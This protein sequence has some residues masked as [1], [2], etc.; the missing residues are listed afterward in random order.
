M[1]DYN[2]KDG[3][4]YEGSRTPGIGHQIGNIKDGRIYDGGSFPG[5]GRQVGNIKEG[6]VY[7]GSSFPGSGNKIGTVDDFLINGIQREKD[8][9]IVAVYHFLIKKIF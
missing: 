3:R 7:N 2:F 6:K 5:S 8:E 4:V 1:T 9:T